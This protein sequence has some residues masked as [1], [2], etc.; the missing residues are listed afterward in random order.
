[1]SKKVTKSAKNG[2]KIQ[3]SRA[4]CILLVAGVKRTFLAHVGPSE[5][6]EE[7]LLQQELREWRKKV[8]Q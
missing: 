5:H 3:F 1:M 4:Q 6:Q 2:P 8:L 7:H